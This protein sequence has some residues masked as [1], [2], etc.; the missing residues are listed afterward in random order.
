VLDGSPKL[1]AIDEEANH[2]IVHGRRFGKAN[3][4]VHETLDPRSE[5]D[6]RALDFLHVR[7]AHV[8]RLGGQMALVGAPA[9][10]VEAADPKR[11]AQ[12]WQLQKDLIR[13]SPKNVG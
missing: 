6:M 11:L 5:I 7:F 1:V 13:V 4:T 12:R 9:I 2:Q 3:R 8:V 10:R